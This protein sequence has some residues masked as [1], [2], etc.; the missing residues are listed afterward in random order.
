MT[1]MDGI[2]TMT[3]GAKT[4]VLWQEAFGVISLLNLRKSI[5]FNKYF[6][7]K[8]LELEQF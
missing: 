7:K 6:G 4:Q 3:I 2:H 8:E 5:Q 1:L